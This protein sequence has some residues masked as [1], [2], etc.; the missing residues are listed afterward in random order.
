MNNLPANT[1]WLWIKQGFRYFRQQPMEFSTLFLAYL[2]IMLVLGFIPYAGQV[3]AFILM[4]LFTLSFMQGCKGIDQG[5]RVSPKLLIAGFQSQE[6]GKLLLL[7]VLYL[8]AASIAL[9][10]STFI[11]DGVFFDIISGQM[12]LNASNV[13]DTN[14]AGA[15]LF[16]MLI[17]LP[18][19]MAFWFAGPLIAW[20]KMSLFKAVF[21]S[22]FASCKSVRVFLQDRTSIFS[23]ETCQHRDTGTADTE[24]SSGSYFDRQ[25]L[26]RK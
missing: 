15:M 20:Q 5:L 19:M 1:G 22:F 24:R 11:D 17:Y 25:Y 3:L 16:A 2:F 18:A 4:P 23:G 13:E 26:D 9:G 7:G 8:I 21:Y 6:M 12:E 10:A 14:M